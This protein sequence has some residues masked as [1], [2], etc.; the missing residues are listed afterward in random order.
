V[1]CPADFA[2]AVGEKLGKPIVMQITHL[3]LADIRPLQRLLKKKQALQTKMDQLDRMIER[4]GSSNSRGVT[5][6]SGEGTLSRHGAL[7][8]GITEA[9]QKAGKQ[10]LHI[11]ELA[12]NL[13]VK[14]PNIRVWFYS[15]GRKI[16]NIKKVGRARYGW[17]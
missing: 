5:G 12:S 6:V 13:G 8:A 17:V 11:K 10:G 2:S 14:E 15:T 9:L 16:K 3:T 7:K 4:I 1:G